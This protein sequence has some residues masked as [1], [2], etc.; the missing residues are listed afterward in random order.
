MSKAPIAKSR[1][2]SP[3]YRLIAAGQL[4]RQALLAPSREHGLEPGDDA[5]L[6]ILA[7]SR[8]ATAAALVEATGLA[9][10]PLRA[11]IARLIDRDL[12]TL[13]V[14]GPNMLP[15]PRLTTKGARL[16]ALL[17]EHWDELEA[18]LLGELKPNQRR[19]FGKRLDRIVSLLLA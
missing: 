2:R 1:D 5:L 9:A 7:S 15:S 17:A 11:R 19:T 12:V 14:S 16:A 4:V 3:L 18:A 10:E 6:H 13:R 8:N